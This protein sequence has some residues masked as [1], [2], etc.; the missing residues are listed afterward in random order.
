MNTARSAILSPCIGVCE[1]AADGLCTG[2]L[3]DLSEIARWS[4]MSDTE[5][6]R[7]MNEV[8]PDRESRLR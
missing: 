1:V 6:L 4:Q 8:L 2:C 3:R 7:I 5:R